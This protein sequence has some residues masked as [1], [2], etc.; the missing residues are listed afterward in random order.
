MTDT[1]FLGP[2]LRV[3]RVFFYL[4]WEDFTMRESTLVL[5]GWTVS[6]VNWLLSV[7][8]SR[9]L[10]NGVNKNFITGYIPFHESE[11]QLIS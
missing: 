8:R 7:K 2:S 1:V 11:H 10:D 9:N 4:G 5:T 3:V 6:Y